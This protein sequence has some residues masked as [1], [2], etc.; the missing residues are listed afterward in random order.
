[1]KPRPG[2][3]GKGTCKHTDA[4]P[5]GKP[6]TVPSP[7]DVQLPTQEFPGPACGRA[8]R[9]AAGRGANRARA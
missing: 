8:P 6:L 2:L 7:F 1:M 5:F 4:V 9:T 3:L